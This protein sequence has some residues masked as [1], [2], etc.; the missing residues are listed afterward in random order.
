M[1]LRKNPVLVFWNSEALNN[2]GATTFIFLY[3]MLA[4]GSNSVLEWYQCLWCPNKHY[5]GD[6]SHGKTKQV[7]D[8]QL[9]QLPHQAHAIQVPRSLHHSVQ[10]GCKTWTLNLRGHITQ[11]TVLWTHVSTETV[12]HLLHRALD[13]CIVTWKQH[14]FAHKIP[15]WRP[16]NDES[17]LGFVARHDSPCKTVLR[18]TLEEV[19]RR[20]CQNESWMDNVT[21]H[22]RPY[23]RKIYVS[24]SLIPPP[25]PDWSR[26]WW[27]LNVGSILR[28]MLL[29][30]GRQSTCPI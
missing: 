7:V 2:Y 18:D 8:K 21:A 5:H 28:C 4:L 22:D 15:S 25:A 12:P 14:V 23:W 27:W 10:Y 26:E 1:S 17:W 20:G 6:C 3:L 11:D 29:G 13:Q 30:A 9:H 19:R 24:S 16:S